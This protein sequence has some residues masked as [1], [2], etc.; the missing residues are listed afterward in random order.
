MTIHYFT[1]GMMINM[2]YQTSRIIDPHKNDIKVLSIIPFSC[3]GVFDIFDKKI[4]LI[5]N[6]FLN[7]FR[8]IKDYLKYSKILLKIKH[9]V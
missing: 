4:L 8:S 2:F 9:L 1:I 6:L 5:N 7:I 3:L